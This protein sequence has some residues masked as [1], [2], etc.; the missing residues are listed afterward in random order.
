M[1]PSNV[2]FS[3]P[4]VLTEKKDFSLRLVIFHIFF[5]NNNN[6]KEKKNICKSLKS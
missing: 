5:N 2:T 1:A 6:K 4:V 3:V